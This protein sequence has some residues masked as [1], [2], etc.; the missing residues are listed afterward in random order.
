MP[1]LEENRSAFM[2][3]LCAHMLQLYTR[4]A[5]ECHVEG[6]VMS[7]EKGLQGALTPCGIKL[8]QTSQFNQGHWNQSGWSGQNWITIFST[9]FG[10]TV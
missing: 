6:F 1:K 2:L 9:W 10:N 4:T 8:E 7:C 3:D 5:N